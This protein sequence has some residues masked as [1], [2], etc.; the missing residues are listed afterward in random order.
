MIFFMKNLTKTLTLLILLI[1]TITFAQDFYIGVGGTIVSSTFDATE[2]NKELSTY[3]VNSIDD[4]QY[5]N[6]GISAKIR[7]KATERIGANLGYSYIFSTKKD[8]TLN[9]DLPIIGK[10][11]INAPTN[12]SA[13]NFSLDITYS[14]LENKLID[15]FALAGVDYSIG[16]LS[17][18]YPDTVK[19]LVNDISKYENYDDSV[20]GINFG[21]GVTTKIGIFAEVKSKHDFSQYQATLGYLYKF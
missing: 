11:S 5:D 21:A 13:N 6:W 12:I 16:K 1:S 4:I 18:E 10:Q 9:A 2:I 7:I 17:V 8:V 20:V 19:N 14:F 15:V 3:G